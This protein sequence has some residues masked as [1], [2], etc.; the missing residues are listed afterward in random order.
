[1]K[2]ISDTEIFFKKSSQMSNKFFYPSV[3]LFETFEIRTV[4]INC[5]EQ[6]VDKDHFVF[7]LS[8]EYTDLHPRE[9]FSYEGRS[10]LREHLPSAPLGGDQHMH[11]DRLKTK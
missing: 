10:S 7:T 11:S 1:M 9:V 3:I 2:H 4:H 8:L 5:K 6:V